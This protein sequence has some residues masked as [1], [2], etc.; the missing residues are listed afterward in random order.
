MEP[1]YGLCADIDQHDPRQVNIRDLV[2]KLYQIM[3]SL[4]EDGAYEQALRRLT[5]LI[6]EGAVFGYKVFTQP[7]EW[8]FDWSS[9]RSSQVPELVSFPALS[10]TTDDHGHF[11]PV[12]ELKVHATV[13]GSD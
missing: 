8:T 13:A 6:C 9:S 4:S 7:S 3:Q 5:R 10:K 12:P 11:L 1:T 2:N